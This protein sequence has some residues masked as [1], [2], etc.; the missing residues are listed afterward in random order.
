VADNGNKNIR[1]IMSDG[2][3][4]TLRDAGNAAAF[5]SPSGIAVDDKGQVYVADQDGFRVMVGKPLK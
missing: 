5:G 3:V 2:V 1:K 4:K